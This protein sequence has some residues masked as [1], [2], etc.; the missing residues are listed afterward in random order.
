MGYF[1][2]K[3]RMRLYEEK[4]SKRSKMSKCILTEGLSIEKKQELLSAVDALETAILT[5][6]G[7]AT[8]VG[9]LL[10]G[11]V[12]ANLER[13]MIGDLQNMLDAEYWGGDTVENIRDGIQSEDP[14]YI[15]EGL[16]ESVENH[17][18]EEIPE[19]PQGEVNTGIALSLSNLIKD[20]WEAIDGYNSVIITIM[21]DDKV[22]QSLKKNVK[23]VL[24]EIV[25]EE[26]LH[27]GQLQELLKS[28]SP[29][30]ELIN[31]GEEEA[32]EQIN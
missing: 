29:N 10:G 6:M 17:D 3:E 7:A 23:A 21:Q 16:N 18:G 4:V 15:P 1:D 31:K 27:V 32:K 22:P 25:G 8:T 24:T 5:A 19:G 9:K 14:D 28:V 2:R 11:R 30:A 20:E 12:E 26:N 13:Y